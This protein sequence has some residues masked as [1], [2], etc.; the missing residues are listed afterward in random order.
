MQQQ[1]NASQTLEMKSEFI[2][3]LALSCGL[4]INLPQQQSQLVQQQQ[5]QVQQSQQVQQQ[6]Q[7]VQQPRR[8]GPKPKPKQTPIGPPRRR[9]RPSTKDKEN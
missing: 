4:Q 9:G 8:R 6:Q 3:N 1:L 2:R 5:Q 7:Q